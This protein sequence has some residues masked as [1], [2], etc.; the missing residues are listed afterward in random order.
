MFS[1]RGFEM[2]ILALLSFISVQTPENKT[3]TFCIYSML[4]SS[5]HLK[6]CVYF[7]QY[8]V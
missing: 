4:I 5:K 7:I 6:S 3:K 2:H 8:Q 1:E